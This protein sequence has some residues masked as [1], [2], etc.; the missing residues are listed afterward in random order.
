MKNFNFLLQKYNLSESFAPNVQPD[1]LSEKDVHNL[2]GH[3]S[4]SNL[5]MTNSKFQVIDI[6][7]SELDDLLDAPPSNP[8]E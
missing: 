4:C 7:D 1:N 2:S 8:L 3:E 6:N 5:K